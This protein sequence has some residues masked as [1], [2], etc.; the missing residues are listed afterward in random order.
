MMKQEQWGKHQCEIKM[1]FM[2]IKNMHIIYNEKAWLKINNAKTEC[3]Q[4]TK[5]SKNCK[6]KKKFQY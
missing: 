5:F 4:F 6:K 1:L 2:F 3:N